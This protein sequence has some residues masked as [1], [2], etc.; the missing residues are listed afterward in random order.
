MLKLMEVI[1]GL[2]EPC[3]QCAKAIVLEMAYKLHITVQRVYTSA[4]EEEM[5][6][7]Y[8]KGIGILYTIDGSPLLYDN[9]HA[10]IE[11][12]AHLTDKKVGHLVGLP[13]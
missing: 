12:L 5:A 2:C 9:R 13:V 4:V 8:G 7:L 10:A 3:G 6:W 1:L 11:H